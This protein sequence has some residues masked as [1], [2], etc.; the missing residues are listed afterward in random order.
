[1]NSNAYI[2]KLKRDL[3]KINEQLD[4]TLSQEK[5]RQLRMMQQA[6]QAKMVEAER[7]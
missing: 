7:H 3:E 4:S 1:M 2:E 5:A 6:M